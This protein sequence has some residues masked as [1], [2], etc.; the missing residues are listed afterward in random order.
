MYTTPATATA[1][2]RARAR[3]FD[4]IPTSGWFAFDKAGNVITLSVAI[5]GQLHN[6]GI[7]TT[8]YVATKVATESPPPVAVA[9][10]MAEA[11]ARHEG[12]PLVS[13]LSAY[14]GRPLAWRWAQF[15]GVQKATFRE[16]DL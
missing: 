5:V 8:R 4:A 13:R 12:Q 11:M 15:F 16:W 6:F 14:D 9:V 3:A 1:A 7:D 2:A 10:A